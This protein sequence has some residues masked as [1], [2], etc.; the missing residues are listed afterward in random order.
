VATTPGADVMIEAVEQFRRAIEVAGITPP[1][2]IEPDG[3]LHRFSTNG[4]PGDDSG[5]LILHGDGLAAGAFG[6]WR[7]GVSHTWRAD[8]GRELTAAENKENRK[9]MAAIQAERE[10]D[11]ASRHAEAA[12]KAAALWKAAK[13]CEANLYLERKGV[14]ATETL[15]EIDAGAASD[16]L[17]YAPKSR[18]EPLTGRILLVPVKIGDAI[19]TLEMIDGNGRKSAIYG[20]QKSGGYWA[21]QPMP[22]SLET[23]LIGEGVATVLS[24][25]E[26]TGHPAI[27]ALSSSNLKNVAVAMR[28]KYPG[29]RIIICGDLGNGQAKALEAASAVNG[30]LALPEFSADELTADKPP[31]DFNDLAQLRGLE[32]VKALI[33]YT[34]RAPAPGQTAPPANEAGEGFEAAVA[35]LAALKAHEYDRV[36][37]DETKLLGVQIK[38]LDDAVAGQRARQ[39]GGGAAALFPDVEPWPD[40]VNGAALLDE[41]AGTVKRFIACDPEIA[42]VAAL[43]ISFTW[44]VDHFHIAPMIL[45]TAPEM[46]CGKTQLL[47]LIG[48]MV[49]RPISASNI[50]PAVIYHIVESEAPTLLIDEADSF[51]RDNED[52]RGI[53]NSGHGRDSAYVL[54]MVRTAGDNFTPKR[55]STWGPKVLC[56][57][58]R[59]QSTLMDRSLV[60]ELRR[61]GPGERA[62]KLRHA[63]P[64]AFRAIASKLAK[65]ADDNA[66]EVGKAR[67]DI[68]HAL[69]DRAQDNWEPLLAIADHAGGG[70][71]ERARAA[72]LKMAGA[73]L[74]VTGQEGGLL[75]DIAAAF[76][77]SGQDRISTAD[78]LAALIADDTKPYA[79]W[80][81]GKPMTARHLANKLAGYRIA[82]RTIRIGSATPKGFLL[83]DF[84][85][86][87][88][89]YLPSSPDTPFLS[90]TPPQPAE[91]LG[92][93][94]NLSATSLPDVA[95]RKVQKPAETL[96]CGGVADRN[97]LPAQEGCFDVA[98]SELEAD[99]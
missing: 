83:S 13:P 60:L 95:A 27:A 29:A 51:F 84:A 59:L 70:W 11:T 15:R 75:Q 57:I 67:P 19:S 31:S 24:A 74:E 25:Y 92:L 86:T 8:I 91:T 73:E 1:V 66:A 82:P 54:R 46:R 30:S 64:A 85:D 47:T 42:E 99:L 26:A 53:I 97:P 89:R 77:A 52:L 39:D 44:L 61:K 80:A 81:R 23:L 41:I 40:P 18:G 56:G 69:H 35:R 65:Y 62:E 98:E 63:D 38:T 6:C 32:A 94:Y 93:L 28:A 7:T 20:G 21:A 34:E 58:G 16:I 3:K 90:A 33:Q 68:P 22:D 96:A 36:R 14:F 10:A 48:K 88:S 12:K 76:S 2:R 9:Q 72:A 78:L 4:K 17:G 5:W 71:P 79:T 50:S 45:I 87:F 55:F 49:K 37:K 43:W